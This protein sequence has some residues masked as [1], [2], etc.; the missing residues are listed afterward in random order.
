[1]NPKKVIGTAQ[2]LN[3]LMPGAG[4]LYLGQKQSATTAFFLRMDFSSPPPPIFFM[5][6]TS[7]QV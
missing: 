2:A 6:G 4:Y 7:P 3:A 1:M 5:T